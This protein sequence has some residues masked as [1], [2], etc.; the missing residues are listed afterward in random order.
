MQAHLQA[1]FTWYCWDL[2]WTSFKAFCANLE[3]GTKPMD[4][5]PS[6]LPHTGRV[7]INALMLF[8]DSYLL[9]NNQGQGKSYIISSNNTIIKSM[10]QK[11]PSLAFH[12]I[13]ILLYFKLKWE[14]SRQFITHVTYIFFYKQHT[15]YK[16]ASVAIIV[17]LQNT[18]N[19]IMCQT[20]VT[21]TT[22]YDI[23]TMQHESA[24][25]SSTNSSMLNINKTD[26][27]HRTKT[28]TIMGSV[29]VFFIGSSQQLLLR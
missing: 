11:G 27:K 29:Y 19:T 12:S 8:W 9:W 15:W 24:S 14:T 3:E 17:Q 4:V 16:S 25:R 20:G 13:Y 6:C 2:L 21:N 28:E 26:M 10:L 5:I 22:N 1:C 23:S 18:S 7:L